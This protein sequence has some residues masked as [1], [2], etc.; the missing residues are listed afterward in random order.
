MANDGL[1][2]QVFVK[3]HTKYFYQ[4][5][6]YSD[7]DTAYSSDSQTYSFI[8]WSL[9]EEELHKLIERIN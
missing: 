7:T 1:L 8:R 2:K 5:Q 6:F 3:N 9:A 4:I